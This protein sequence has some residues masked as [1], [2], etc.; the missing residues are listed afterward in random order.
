MKVQNGGTRTLSSSS[1]FAK[2]SVFEGFHCF[3]PCSVFHILHKLHTYPDLTLRGFIENYAS[4]HETGYHSPSSDEAPP[5]TPVSFP[6]YKK[7]VQ[8]YSKKC[9]QTTTQ[10]CVQICA[11]LRTVDGTTTGDFCTHNSS[12]LYAAAPGSVS[13]L[14]SPG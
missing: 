13:A 7:S 3:Q 1:S 11:D 6:P 2:S 10:T 9:V 14:A 5:G 12:Y 4:S 8:N